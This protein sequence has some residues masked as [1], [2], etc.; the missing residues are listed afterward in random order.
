MDD[1]RVVRLVL[2]KMLTELGY[3][4]AEAGKGE[5]AVS[6]YEKALNDGNPFEAVILDLTVKAGMGGVETLDKLRELDPKVKAMISTGYADKEP[7]ELASDLGVQGILIK[8]FGLEDLETLLEG[9]L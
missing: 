9:L 2:G 8:P 4:M 5:E 7:D 6:L 3:D 1:E